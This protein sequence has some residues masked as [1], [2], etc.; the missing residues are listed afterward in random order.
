MEKQ[1][2]VEFVRD[3][4][5]LRK[6]GKWYQHVAMVGNK[7][8]RLKGYK[9]WLQIYDVNGVNHAN[10]M[11]RKVKEFNNDLLKPFYKTK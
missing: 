2:L 4:N 10:P 11:D 8:V 6:T 9:T 1:T 7:Q 3:V 5:D